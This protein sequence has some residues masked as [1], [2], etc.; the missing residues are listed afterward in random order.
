MALV[1][2]SSALFT[3]PPMA[4]SAEGVRAAAPMMLTTC[5]V[6]LSRS[7]GQAARVI[8]TAPWNFKAKPSRKS[9]CDSAKKSP[10]FVAPAQ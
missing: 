5:P 8:A 10:R 9:S 7:R 2:F 3:A 6:P 4:K 1:K